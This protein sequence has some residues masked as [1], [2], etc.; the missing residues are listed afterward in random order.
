M[1]KQ[2]IKYFP[3][4][5]KGRIETPGG[6]KIF[7]NILW[8]YGDKIFR[9]GGGLLIGIMIAR[10]LGPANYGL[11][12]FAFSFVW[13]FENVVTLGMNEVLM[14]EIVFYPDKKKELLGSAFG[15]RLLGGTVS[16]ILIT[17]GI[18]WL[19]PDN[20]VRIIVLI[21]AIGMVIKN[22]GVIKFYF[23]ANVKSKYSV[24]AENISYV[25]FSV[26][27]LILILVHYPLIA[28]VWA[29]TAEAIISSIFY[30][31]FYRKLGTTILDWKFNGSLAKKLIRDSWLLIFTGLFI[32]IYVRGDQV[33][34]AQMAGDS[35]AGIYSAAVRISELWLFIPATIVVSFFPSIAASKEISRNQYFIKLQ[36]L[37]DI[38][39]V[40]SVVVTLPVSILSPLIISILYGHAYQQ[41]ATVLSI[42]I[43]SATF[44]ILM[45]A[46]A[47]YLIIENLQK[48]LFIRSLFGAV[49]NVVLNL[50]FIPLFGPAGAATATLLSY[51]LATFSTYYFPK[52]RQITNVM[53]SSFNFFRIYRLYAVKK[54]GGN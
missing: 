12:N 30:I 41:A 51:G 25:L 9:L 3:A 15:L 11:Y 42:H 29:Y 21:M 39:T 49:L 5:L 18:F 43:W 33:L 26:I 32:M 13:I 44:L 53:F 14:R 2:V 1:Y 17:A 40:I 48:Y 22:A 10:Y 6:K 23:E 54:E 52:T 37:F 34:I 4:Q 36:Q 16:F 50:I 45:V 7:Q 28:F 8:L 47:R 35:S 31:F 20:E 46:S 19:R 38:I 24:I 27:K